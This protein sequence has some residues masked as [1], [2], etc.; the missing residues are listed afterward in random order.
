M[1]DM[2]WVPDDGMATRPYLTFSPFIG[3]EIPTFD[4]SPELGLLLARK[5]TLKMKE[6][7]LFYRCK[8]TFTLLSHP[9]GRWG[10]R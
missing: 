5:F 8:L 10:E 2:R 1:Y 3:R 9:E 4:L 7:S 6:Y